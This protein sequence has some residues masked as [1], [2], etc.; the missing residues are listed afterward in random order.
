MNGGSI[1]FRIRRGI[2]PDQRHGAA[3]LYWQA[4]GGKL[5]R[6]LGPERKAL[7][8]VERVMCPDHALVAIASGG[9]V[10]GV[11][12][13]RTRVGSFVGGSQAD[14]EAV[15]GRLGGYWRGL[16]LSYV[17]RDLPDGMLIVDGLSVDPAHRGRGIGTALMRAL[18]A[19]AAARGYAEVRLDVVGENLRARALYDRL[20]FAV[21]HRHDSWLTRLVFDYRLTF[22]M[23]LRL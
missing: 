23:G 11:V 13:F 9:E 4:F 19:E 16:C 1:T 20:G 21:L 8:L 2:A 18:C 6:V 15:Y 5:G 12:G 10:L 7:S 3:R 14:L 17:A 22:E